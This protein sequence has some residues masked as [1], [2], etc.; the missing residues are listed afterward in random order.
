M[1]LPETS[2]SPKNHF[3]RRRKF[4]KAPKIV[5]QTAGKFRKP[6]KSFLKTA[7]SSGSFKNHFPGFRELPKRYLFY[8]YHKFITMKQINLKF[9]LSRARNAEHY[10]FHSDILRIITLDFASEQ[11]IETLRTPYQELFDT[12]NTCYLRNAKLQDTPEVEAADKTRDN[13]FLYVSQTITTGLLC[14]IEATATAAKRLDYHLAPYKDAPRLTYA[15]NTAAVTDFVDKMQQEGIKE[16]VATLGLTA[17]ITQLGE[18]NK[19]FNDLYS[20]RSA[21][22]LARTTSDNMKSIRPKVDDAYKELAS[23]VN[24]L[25]QVNF[26]VTKSSDKET[27]IGAVIDEVNAIILQLQNTLSRAGVGPKPNFTPADKQEPSTP[28]GGGEE[29]RPGEL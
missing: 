23:A 12:E 16:D 27:S 8:S 21:E 2:E 22:V 9:D 25:Y 10:Q 4:P 17:V 11:G 28:S 7:E 15:A 1:K 29:E 6:E 14:P 3:S 19:A 24:A 13:L 5:F 18:A 26:L 20:G